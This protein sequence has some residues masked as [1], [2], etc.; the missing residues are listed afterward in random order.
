MAHSPLF[1]RR[2]HIAGSIDKNPLAASQEEATKARE[3][4]DGLVKALIKRG[5]NFVVPVDRDPTRDADG[6]KAEESG[7][8]RGA[9]GR[10]TPTRWSRGASTRCHRR[11]G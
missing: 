4:I 1:G 7:R 9:A 5:A 11:R 6:E 2:I 8:Q 3:L 10:S